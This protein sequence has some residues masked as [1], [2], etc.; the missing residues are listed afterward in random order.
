[1]QCPGCNLTSSGEKYRLIEHK[2]NC[3]Q[4]WKLD[5]IQ[6]HYHQWCK[7]L[8]IDR[9]DV[10]L[11][12]KKYEMTFFYSVNYGTGDQKEPFRMPLDKLQIRFLSQHKADQIYEDDELIIFIK[13]VNVLSRDDKVFLRKSLADFVCKKNE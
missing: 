13:Y 1:M 5:N 6:P 3:V 4:F 2:K 7:E 11:L 10:W 12:N 9:Y 8:S